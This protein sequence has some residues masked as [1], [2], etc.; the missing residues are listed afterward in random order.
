V[1]RLKL[2]YVGVVAA[3]LAFVG[4]LLPWF[5]V[6]LTSVDGAINMD[7]S[8]YLYQIQ[9][10]VNGVSATSFANVWFVWGALALIIITAICCLVGSFFTGRKGQVLLLMAGIFALLSA[11]VFGAGLLNSSYSNTDTEPASVMGL[12]PSNAFAPITA[13]TAMQNSYDIAWWLSYGF[14]LTIVGAIMAFVGAVTP[15]LLSKKTA[16]S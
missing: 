13:D 16:S 5:T 7:F 3:V 6:T 15:S 8:V 14:W 9:G 12:F 10:T 11:V 4:L 2:N 1:N